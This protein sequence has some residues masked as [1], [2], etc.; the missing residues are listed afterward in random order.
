[1]RRSVAAAFD[2]AAAPASLSAIKICSTRVNAPQE[3]QA[4]RM[5]KK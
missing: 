1:M 2:F 3:K 5:P 4:C